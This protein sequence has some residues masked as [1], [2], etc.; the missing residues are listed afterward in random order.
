[1]KEIAVSYKDEN[2]EE[3]NLTGSDVAKYIS[4]DE[5]VTEKE[6]FMFLNMCRY[7]RLNPFLK[8][9]YLV[10]YRGSPAVLEVAVYIIL[11]I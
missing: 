5:S 1:M 9:I 7:L 11:L 8:E 6:V 2:G 4:T 10:K 3:V